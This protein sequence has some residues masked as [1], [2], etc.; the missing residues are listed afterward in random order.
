[1]FLSQKSLKISFYPLSFFGALVVSAVFL[2]VRHGGLLKPISLPSPRPY[3][4]ISASAVLEPSVSP[5]RSPSGT[6]APSLTAIPPVGTALPLETN[7]AV[8]FTSQAPHGIWDAPWEEFCEEASTLMAVS[9]VKG[10]S[11]PDAD[12][13]AGEMLKVKIFEEQR[14]GYYQDTTAEETAI[15]LREHFGLARVEVRYAPSIAD[16]IKELAEGKVVVVPAAG[17]ELPNPYYRSPGPLYHML[18]IKGYTKDG[19]FITNDPGTKRG[20]DFLYDQKALFSAIHDWNGGNVEEG[21]SVM[22]VVG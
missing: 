18:V 16:I 6:F 11:I 4:K 3:G 14:F 15:I 10:T 2:Y 7:L 19:R 17:R 13:A 1:M 22:I 9:F 21:R 5:S 8:P 20:A 12:F